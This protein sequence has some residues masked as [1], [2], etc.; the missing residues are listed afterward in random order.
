[1]ATFG[2]EINSKAPTLKLTLIPS[3]FE[4]VRT[5]SYIRVLGVIELIEFNHSGLFGVVG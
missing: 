1:M 3:T 2:N 5:L 4:S